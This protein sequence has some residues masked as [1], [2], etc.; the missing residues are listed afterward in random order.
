MGVGEEK[1]RERRKERPIPVVL[2]HKRA[3]SSKPTWVTHSLRIIYMINDIIY[4]RYM[5][6]FEV[7]INY[8]EPRVH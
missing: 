3:A 6:N 4:I 7:E 1:G 5:L 8:K 2:A